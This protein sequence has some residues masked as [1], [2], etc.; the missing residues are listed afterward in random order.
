MKKTYYFP[1]DYHARHDHKLVKLRKD[2][3]VLGYGLY[4]F[5]VEVLYETGDCYPFTGLDV[6]A[7]ESG[8]TEDLIKQVITDYNLFSYDDEVFWSDSQRDRIAKMSEI[9][10]KRKK[11]GSMG[12]KARSAKQTKPEFDEDYYKVV[13]EKGNKIK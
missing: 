5:I 12:G 2:H 3:G 13:L 11:A 7:Y 1:H 8:V 6:I 9:H 10:E 4:W